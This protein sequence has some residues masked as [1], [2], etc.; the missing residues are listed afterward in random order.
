[1]NRFAT[2]LL[3]LVCALLLSQCAGPPPA[4]G[5]SVFHGKQA[6]AYRLG[7]HHGFMDGTG[8]LDDNFERYHDEFRPEGREA[9]ARG[10]QAGHE[11]GRR[12]AAADDT[13][14]DRAYQNGHDAGLADAENGAKPDY[15]RYRNQFNAG[16]APSFRDGY[17]KG[18]EEARRQ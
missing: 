10:Y 2:S 18:W 13:D 4:P 3:T 8:K 12:G 9:F 7:Y 17:E 15:R 16:S 6:S 1:M 14:L 11:S 5:D